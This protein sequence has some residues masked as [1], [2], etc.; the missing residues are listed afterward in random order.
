MEKKKEQVIQFLK[1]HW[2]IILI[3]VLVIT[4]SNLWEENR[5]LKF[6]SINYKSIPNINLTNTLT[7]YPDSSSFT[8]EMRGFVKLSN[9]NDQPKDT[10]QYYTIDTTTNKDIL[11]LDEIVALNNL[12]PQSIGKTKLIKKGES[13]DII[14]LEDQNGLQLFYNKN[15][16]EVFMDDA[17]L[18]TNDSDYENFMRGFL[19]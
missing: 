10:R 13:G 18:I 2:K 6:A 11:V 1:K 19:K 16:K 8:G 9:E 12:P 7:Y 3:V 4:A 17:K 5:N 15:S 14:T